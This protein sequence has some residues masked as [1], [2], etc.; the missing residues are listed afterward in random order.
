ME[1]CGM[2]SVACRLYVDLQAGY[3]IVGFNGNTETDL[4]PLECSRHLSGTIAARQP[5][6]VKLGVCRSNLLDV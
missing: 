5:R 2:L 6:A 1:W 4:N 3:V